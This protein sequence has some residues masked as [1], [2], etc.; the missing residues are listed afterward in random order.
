MIL[1]HFEFILHVFLILN[2][3]K[4][5]VSSSLLLSDRSETLMFLITYETSLIKFSSSLLFFAME[6]FD[7]TMFSSA[8]G[9]DTMIGAWSEESHHS[10]W[11]EWLLSS[12]DPLYRN[13]K[14][15]TEFA[16]PTISKYLVG[17]WLVRIDKSKLNKSAMIIRSLLIV[18]WWGKGSQ[19]LSLILNLLVIISKFG[20]FTSVF[21]RYFKVEWEESE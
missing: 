9:M 3:R 18:E 10:G 1:T 4:L 20:I 7:I 16:L 6:N 8:I 2:A 19:I 12:L 13:I 17:T 15:M 5:V 21:L 14:S 11:M